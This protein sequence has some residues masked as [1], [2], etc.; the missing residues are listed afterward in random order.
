MTNK[1]HV[2]LFEAIA[3]VSQKDAN[4]VTV[5]EYNRLKMT[6]NYR[7]AKGT[8]RSKKEDRLILLNRQDVETYRDQYQEKLDG[9]GR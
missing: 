1:E 6:I 2:T 5:K 3:I 8:I 7:T 4:N 9:V